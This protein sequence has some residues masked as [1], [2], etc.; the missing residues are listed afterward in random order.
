M[1]QHLNA[2][3]REHL[4]EMRLERLSAADCFWVDQGAR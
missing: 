1:G 4:H 3:N 2:E